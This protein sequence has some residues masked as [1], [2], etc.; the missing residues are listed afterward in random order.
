MDDAE[1]PDLGAATMEDAIIGEGDE[2]GSARPE[3]GFEDWPDDDE[4][5][6]V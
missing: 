4:V 3:D 6:A 1:D 5:K 2:A